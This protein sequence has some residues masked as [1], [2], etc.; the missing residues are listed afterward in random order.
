MT[1]PDDALE[2]VD[3]AELLDDVARTI[4]RY[5]IL[6]STSALTA[7][8]LW[9]AAT[10]AVPAWNCAPRLVI[11]APE[12]RCGKS[13]LLDMIEGM[14]HRPLMT[15]NASPSA[16]YRSI[17][18]KPSDPPTLL[19]DEADTI[20]G[21]KAGDN[22][23]LRGLLNA[24]HQR[25]RHTIRYSA[26]RD[27]VDHLQTFAMAALAGIGVMPDTIEDRAAVIRM[28]RRAPGESVQPYRVRRDGPDL[29][30]LRDELNR[31]L[32]AHMDELTEATPDMPVEDRAADTWEPMVAVADL[33]GGQWPRAAR[34]A[35]VALTSDRDAGDEASLHTRLLS[36]CRTAF[37]DA[38][39]LPT[40]ELLVRLKG[41]SEAPWATYGVNG[42]SAMKLG[43]L[44][45]D[46]EIRS[47]NIRFTTGQAKGYTRSDFADAWSRYCPQ[48][49]TAP[50]EEGV[51]A[52]PGVRAQVTPGTASPSGT[53]QAV[54]TPQAVPGLTCDATA[55]TAGTAWRPR[56]VPDLFDGDT[57]RETA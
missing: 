9:I 45:R 47:S 15:T 10:H 28:R 55:G 8:V 34:K 19:I 2:P 33:A 32:K 31:W 40:A 25:G 42:L 24:G 44:L 3:G 12:K 5:V 13:R 39:A 38:D 22:E 20:F 54:P 56:A 57:N 50:G 27:D 6:P 46:F 11:R 21:A 1:T 41:D 16:V 35:A 7:V 17:S 51:P 14:C 4:T 49:T 26:A 48:P 18:K 36:D 52:V 30:V 43:N 23:D 53:A 37:Q 29:D